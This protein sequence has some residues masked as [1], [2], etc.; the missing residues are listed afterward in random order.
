MLTEFGNTVVDAE[1]KRGNTV[2]LEV[3]FVSNLEVRLKRSHR[4]QFSFHSL[5]HPGVVH[6]PSCQKHVAHQRLLL[7]WSVPGSHGNTSETH[8]KRDSCHDNMTIK[9][10]NST[11]KCG[12][13]LQNAEIL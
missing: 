6:I 7:L 2:H 9:R 4:Q 5:L 11:E 13:I 8:L 3:A 1:K 12:V 10:Q